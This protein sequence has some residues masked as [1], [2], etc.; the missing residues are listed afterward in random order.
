MNTATRPST[1]WIVVAGIYGALAIAIGAFGAHGLPGLLERQG[2]DAEEIERR[3]ALFDTASRY[4]TY[5]ALAILGV[6]AALLYRPSRVLGLA[7]WLLL[8]GS[9]EFSGLIY[10]LSLAGPNL[11][12]LGMLVPIGGVL[13]IAGWG[14]IAVGGWR[15][16]LAT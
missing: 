15:A 16:R 3:V 10:A 2:Y 11:R 12:W 8:V 5:A 1:R 13:M 14:A 7:C 6:G 9:L 4:H